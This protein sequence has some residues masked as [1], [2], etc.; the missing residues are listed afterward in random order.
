MAARGR[1][2]AM[3]EVATSMAGGKGGCD[4]YAHDRGRILYCGH[5]HDPRVYQ[6]DSVMMPMTGTED[7]DPTYHLIGFAIDYDRVWFIDDG[8]SGLDVLTAANKKRPKKTTNDIRGVYVR[9]FTNPREL[10]AAKRIAAEAEKRG[11]SLAFYSEDD[12]SWITL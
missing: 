6:E 3:F 5:L 8:D 7:S 1:R 12:F 11:V 2:E 4:I 10:A 9:G